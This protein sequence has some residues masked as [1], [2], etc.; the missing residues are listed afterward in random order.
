[1]KKERGRAEDVFQGEF[2]GPRK[3]YKNLS[4]DEGLKIQ[5]NYIANGL[6]QKKRY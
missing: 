3:Y 5:N 1:M 4:R 6:T 2:S